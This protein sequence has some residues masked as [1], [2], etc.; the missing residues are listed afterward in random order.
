MD[1]ILVFGHNFFPAIDGGARLLGLI[2]LEEKKKGKNLRHNK[3]R[4]KK[5]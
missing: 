5:K 4:E 1:N 2:A 3:K